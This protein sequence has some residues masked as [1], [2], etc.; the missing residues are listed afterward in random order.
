MHSRIS[1]PVIC[2]CSHTGSDVIDAATTRWRRRL[3]KMADSERAP[4]ISYKWLDFFIYC[5]NVHE[6][7]CNFQNFA[8]YHLIFSHFTNTDLLC[9]MT[10]KAVSR[11]IRITKHRRRTTNHC[12]DMLDFR[13]FW[14]FA[15]A[16][17]FG[18]SKFKGHR[19]MLLGL[20]SWVM[21]AISIMLLRR[22]VSE[23]QSFKVLGFEL[24]ILTLRGHPRSKV[25]VNMER[26]YMI[27]Y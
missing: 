4:L 12:R 11:P 19:I 22:T 2:I 9:H 10:S 6:I 25:K 23:I 1:F 17:R 20:T 14:H 8:F 7:Y 18:S 24:P 13:F 27:S 21:L 15:N 5:C 3:L 26:P 16:D